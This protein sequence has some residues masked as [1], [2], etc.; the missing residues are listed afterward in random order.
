MIYQRI[1]A[2]GAKR[3]QET[4]RRHPMTPQPGS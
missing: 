3:I 1:G 2:P 4:L